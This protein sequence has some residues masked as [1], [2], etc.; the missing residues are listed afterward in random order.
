MLAANDTAALIDD[1]TVDED[2]APGIGISSSA[3]AGPS[4]CRTGGWESGCVTVL[5]PVHRQDVPQRVPA[6]DANEGQE[7]DG[8]AYVDGVLLHEGEVGEELRRAHATSK[9][10]RN[11]R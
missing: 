10:S 8:S 5:F 1:K 2:G 9:R 7:Y 11:P 4:L 3:T 6:M